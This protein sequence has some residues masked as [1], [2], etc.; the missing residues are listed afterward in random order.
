M[1]KEEQL[2]F[3]KRGFWICF[4]YLLWDTFRIFGLL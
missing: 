4:V 2:D 3:Y 1:N